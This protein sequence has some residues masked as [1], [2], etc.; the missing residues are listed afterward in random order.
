MCVHAPLLI[1][2]SRPVQEKRDIIVRIPTAGFCA[3]SVALRSTGRVEVWCHIYRAVGCG[4]FR[5]GE[6]KHVHG[7]RVQQTHHLATE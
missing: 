7:L 4:V 1:L 6:M 2:G 5:A 3:S